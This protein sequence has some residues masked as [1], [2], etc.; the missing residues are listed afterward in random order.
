[1]I[2]HVGGGEEAAEADSDRPGDVLK[3]S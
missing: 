1:M 3:L 2:G